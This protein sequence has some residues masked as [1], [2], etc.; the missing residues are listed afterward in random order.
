MNRPVAARAALLSHIPALRAFA[1]SLCASRDQGNDLVQETLLR[2]LAHLD[3]FQEGTNMGAWLFNILR[4]HFVNDFCSP[5]H[6]V[7]DVDGLYAEKIVTVPEQEG[8]AISTDL[9]N[10]LARLPRHQREALV[11]VGAS[12][13]T[14]EEAASVC[15][16]EIGT[17]KSRVNR[18]RTRLAQLMAGDIGSADPEGK[19][20]RRLSPREPV[21]TRTIAAH[22]PPPQ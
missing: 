13:L 2:A 10:A 21:V 18:A 8:W 14:L 11:L 22:A 17:I 6:W 5:P 15:E 1:F 4:N 19:K 16:C 9:G 7:P 3:D 20:Y 12:G